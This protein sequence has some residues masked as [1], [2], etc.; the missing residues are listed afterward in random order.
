MVELWWYGHTSCIPKEVFNLFLY[1]INK[2]FIDVSKIQF[3]S[4]FGIFM[5][6]EKKKKKIV[7]TESQAKNLIKA[8][9]RQEDK[10]K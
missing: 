4:D 5:V 2:I 10:K 1:P 7:I 9:I 8:L 3:I 6:M